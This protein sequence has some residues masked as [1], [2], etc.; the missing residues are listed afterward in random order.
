MSSQRTRT[1]A[2]LLSFGALIPAVAPAEPP[3]F[4]APPACG[5]RLSIALK[6]SPL[7]ADGWLEVTGTLKN[8][9]AKPVVLVEPGDG[10]ESGWRTPVLSW[11]ARRIGSGPVRDILLDPGPRCGLMNGPDPQREVF[12][13]APGAS[14]RLSGSPLLIPPPGPPGLYEIVLLYTNDPRI[15]FHGEILGDPARSPYAGSI[16]CTAVSNPLRIEVPANRS[17]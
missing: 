2:L 14:R 12:R 9:G 16:A 15:G 4:P 6:P 7:P 8:E 5:V 11:H 1:A 13:L 3:A 10:S 17:N